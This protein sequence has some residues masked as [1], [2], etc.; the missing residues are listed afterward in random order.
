MDP[1]IE[2]V[3]GIM[4]NYSVAVKRGDLVAIKVYDP[5]AQPLAL[6]VYKH[7]LLSGG[8]AFFNMAP[9][10]AEEVFYT[11][12]EDEQLDFPNAINEWMME[13]A[14][15]LIALKATVNSRTLNN[16]DTAKFMRY[17]NAIAP[18]MKKYLER[19]ASGDLRWT[20]TQYPTQ[21]SAQDADMS[22]SEYEDFVYGAC[23][24]Q[25]DDPVAYWKQ[26]SVEQQRF[27]DW[28]EGKQQIEVKGENIDMTLSIADRTFVNA[29]GTKNFPDGEIFTGPVE[30]S[31]NGWV[32]FTYPAI[33]ENRGVEGVELQ[34]EDGKV[35]SATAEKGQDYLDAVLNTDPGARYLGEFAIGT[36]EGITR[37]TR[38]ILFDEKINGTIHMALG[39]GYPETGN[40]NESAIHWDMICDMRSGGEIIVDGELFYKDGKFQV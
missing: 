37:F 23:M 34:F 14:D 38:N 24:V 33:Y 32:R 19:S 26:R 20:L 16:V 35:V 28:L 8:N 39:A 30:D 3:A 12:A 5:V 6:A 25:L 22:L 15:V 40:T 10:G 29:D 2:K 17:R 7:V 36:N 18:Y 31:V 13:N 11:C 27:I 21:A 4:V 1:R 9:S